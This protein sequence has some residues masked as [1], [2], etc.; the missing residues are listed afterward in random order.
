MT[1][2]RPF[3]ER[4]FVRVRNVHDGFVEFDFAIG[5]P[6]LYVEL[7]LTEGAFEEFCHTN[8]VEH[9]D[10]ESA[11]RLDQDKQAWREGDADRHSSR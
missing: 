4:R 2:Q 3:H 5:D 1:Q 10:E 9:L 8:S 6:Q 7:I 11:T